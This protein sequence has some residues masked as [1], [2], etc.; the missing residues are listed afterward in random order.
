[1]IPKDEC[2]SWLKSKG[3]SWE[4]E[5]GY[6]DF[7]GEEAEDRFWVMPER[8]PGIVYFLTV[9]L[10]AIDPWEYLMVCKQGC[11]SWH[12]DEENDESLIHQVRNH[13]ASSAGVSKD[14]G[15]ALLNGVSA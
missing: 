15:G 13:I 12:D 4:P 10:N 2:V 14:F 9:I 6:I 11:T 5:Y 3:L 8:G 1:M 7:I